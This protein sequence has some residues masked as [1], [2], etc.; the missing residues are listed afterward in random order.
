MDSLLSK[1]GHG[2][3]VGSRKLRTGI[4]AF[5]FESYCCVQ[6]GGFFWSQEYIGLTEDELVFIKPAS[7][8]GVSKRITLPLLALK[9]IRAVPDSELPF[10]ICTAKAF[11]VSTFSRVFLLLVKSSDLQGM[12]I[13]TL[14]HTM[15]A[16]RRALLYNNTDTGSVRH[17][18]LMVRT[19]DFHLDSDQYVMNARS[20]LTGSLCASSHKETAWPQQ[21][22][23]YFLKHPHLIVERLLKKLFRL[24]EVSADED[25]EDSLSEQLWIDFLDGAA[26][27]QRADLSVYS[28]SVEGIISGN[29]DTP[30]ERTDNDSL[31]AMLLN[32]YHVMLLHAYLVLGLPD[33]K[34][35][36]ADL[37]NNYCYE[38][39]G[40]CFSIEQ[41]ENN[42]IRK[43]LLNSEA[44]N[45]YIMN[46]YVSSAQKGGGST[47]IAYKD[48][49]IGAGFSRLPGK[50][51]GNSISG[52]GEVSEYSYGAAISVSDKDSFA[53]S[54]FT[55]KDMRLLF[56]LNTGHSFMPQH[57]CIFSRVQ[58]SSQLDSCTETFVHRCVQVGLI[59]RGIDFA[60]DNKDSPVLVDSSLPTGISSPTHIFGE[61][62]DDTVYISAVPGIDVFLKVIGKM[63]VLSTEDTDEGDVT[64]QQRTKRVQDVLHRKQQVQ[65]FLNSNKGV[66]ISAFENLSTGMKFSGERNFLAFILRH[67]RK[68]SELQRVFTAAVKA[69]HPKTP[70]IKIRKAQ[71]S[72]FHF[73]Q[74]IK[75]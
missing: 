23:S 51:L 65:R 27:L 28:A 39:F 11:S 60:V 14:L 7:R 45:A 56:V 73:L 70:P 68:D 18:D 31:L 5:A 8:L 54:Q 9:E 20:F 4:S 1:P 74:E 19:K 3:G 72:A 61:D 16:R 32:L 44:K 75:L 33:N 13:E 40:D 36:W 62:F 21:D 63:K 41:L 35:K 52:P 46:N 10:T 59:T 48:K 15:Q 12:W 42:I 29:R 17:L 69:R 67:M 49:S 2:G 43:G 53:F 64:P 47:T 26:L 71:F 57:I 66:D 25:A 22:L 55:N 6:Q 37:R 34:R 38:A 30:D 24:V 50:L 58:L